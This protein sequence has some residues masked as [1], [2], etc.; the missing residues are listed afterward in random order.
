MQCLQGNARLRAF[1]E[2]SEREGLQLQFDK[3][4]LD[5][6]I[7]ADLSVDLGVLQGEG[8]STG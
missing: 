1:A 7:N 3:R 2:E 6:E 8:Q 5:K 4:A